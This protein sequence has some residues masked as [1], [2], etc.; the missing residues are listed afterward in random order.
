MT[1]LEFAKVERDAT[2]SA[3]LRVT[4]SQSYKVGQGSRARENQRVEHDRLTT[5]LDELDATIA[6][7]EGAASGIRRVRYIR[8]L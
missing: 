7:L 1:P 2:R 4:E 8:P 5:R 3:I 6:R